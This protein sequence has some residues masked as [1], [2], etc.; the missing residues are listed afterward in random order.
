MSRYLKAIL[1]AFN[2]VIYNLVFAQDVFNLERIE[3]IADKN[4]TLFSFS[5]VFDVS[6]DELQSTPMGVISSQFSKIPGVITTQNGGPGGRTTFFIRGTE[7]RHVSFTI[8]GLKLNDP[9]NTDRQF[10]AAFFS[11][12]MLKTMRLYKGPQAVLLGS[13]SMGGVV[14]LITRKGDQAPETRL[15]LNVGS[16]GTIHSTLA[17]DWKLKRSQGTLTA[18]KFRTDGISRLNKKR[19][20]ATEADSAESTQLTSSSVHSFNQRAETEL[21]FSY[22]RG[23]NELD[24]STSDNS[25]DRSV[26]DQYL[27][28][29]KTNLHLKSNQ[30]LSLRTGL[31]RHQRSLKTIAVGLESYAGD[32][33][34]NELL[35]RWGHKDFQLL[36]GLASEHEDF[37]L[38]QLEK[39]FD[40]HSLFTQ[41]SYQIDRIKL[42]TGVR[43]E[44]H[45]SYGEFFTGSS[46]VSFSEKLHT[47]SFQYSQGYKAPSLYQLYAPSL[48]GS[49]IGNPQLVPE[50][51]HSIEGSWNFKHNFFEANLAY[52]RNS[53][54]NLITYTTSQGY[55]NQG[56]FVVEGVE[57]TGKFTF[58]WF[59]IR[60]SYTVQHFR[61]SKQTVLRRPLNSAQLGLMVFPSQH[62][63][64][65]LNSRWFS[66]RNDLSSTSK[67]VKLNGYESLDFEINYRLRNWDFGVQVLNVFN[68]D[69]EDLYGYSVMPLSFFTH[70]G[71]RF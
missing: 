9:S 12:P 29:Q 30:A 26:N 68:R 66:S 69:Y 21:L 59:Q 6:T 22:L 48:F 44:K 27:A 56:R 62:W 71:M 34:Q 40:L 33:V 54:S 63:E 13:D 18:T 35:W 20:Q 23:L 4:F 65:Q 57:G 46:G 41:A 24:G 36:S 50:V 38:S 31:N 55:L 2:L 10:D 61:E 70:V 53:L 58:D 15:A 60:S 52:F 32:L 49:P 42:Q 45:T 28:Q 7:S 5:P 3:V 8:D 11:S 1:L 37:S 47:W 64:V 39:S 17:Q 51:N 14:E 67:V 19:F 43:A 25:Y 16:F